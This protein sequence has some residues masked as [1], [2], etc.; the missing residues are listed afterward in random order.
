[1]TDKPNAVE[2]II[3]SQLWFLS[4][5]SRREL[6]GEILAAL[7]AAGLKVVKVDK[8]SPIVDLPDSSLQ[9]M[10]CDNIYDPYGTPGEG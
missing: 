5:Q 1:M 9:C 6:P 3:R 7:D 8:D 2:E 4:D 10:R